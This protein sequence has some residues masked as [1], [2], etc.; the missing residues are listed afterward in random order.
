MV[1][2]EVLSLRQPFEGHEAVK[3]AI[4]EGSRPTLTTRVRI[5]AL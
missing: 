1:V 2:Y 4:L 3:E 5:S